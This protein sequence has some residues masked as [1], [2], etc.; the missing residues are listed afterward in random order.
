[1]T[2]VK[3]MAYAVLEAVLE[4]CCGLDVYKRTVTACLLIVP[5]NQPPRDLV[6]TLAKL[7]GW[8]SDLT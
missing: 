3:A 2:K 4:R 5:L 1:M 8:S 6:A 7:K